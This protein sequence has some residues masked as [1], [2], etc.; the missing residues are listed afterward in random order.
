MVLWQWSL[1][2][3]CMCALSSVLVVDM[4][5][6]AARTPHQLARLSRH[7]TSTSDTSAYILPAWQN[8]FNAQCSDHSCPG[9]Q[10]QHDFWCDKI[11]GSLNTAA[12]ATK[13]SSSHKGWG[14][15]KTPAFWAFDVVKETLFIGLTLCE[16]ESVEGMVLS[17]WWLIDTCIRAL[18]SVLWIVAIWIASQILCQDIELGQMLFFQHCKSS[19][20]GN[21]IPG[22]NRIPG[23]RNTAASAT[24]ESSSR[25][26][27]G[28][29]KT[30]A[31]SALHV[32]KETLFIILTLCGD[33][34]CA[35]KGSLSV[36]TAWHLHVCVLSVRCWWL[37]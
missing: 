17:Q 30:P 1:L 27:W 26:G 22:S 7:W 32:T 8:L 3:T 9:L 31:F 23:S 34:K 37:M 15:W 14:A 6:I 29:W 21:V 2:D 20:L 24:K 18:S 10:M 4:N 36:V 5:W 28:A 16:M 13:E 33:G 25:K 19:M 11:P 12:S 35:E